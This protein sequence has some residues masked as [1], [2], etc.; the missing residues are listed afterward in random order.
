MKLF[1]AIAVVAFILVAALYLLRVAAVFVRPATRL[2]DFATN[3]HEQ[4]GLVPEVV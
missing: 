1:T 4:C 2:H 3:R